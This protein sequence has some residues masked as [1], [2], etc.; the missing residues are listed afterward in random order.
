MDATPMHTVLVLEDNRET[1]QW[2]C[3]TLRLHFQGARALAAATCAEAEALLAKAQASGQSID[4]A[5]IDINLPDG[6]GGCWRDAR[7][8]GC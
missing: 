1:R 6:N 7:S 5:L 4:L 2:I 3:E 8:T